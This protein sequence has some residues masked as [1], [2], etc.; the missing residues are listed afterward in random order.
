[1]YKA[2]P[3]TIPKWAVAFQKGLPERLKYSL[4]YGIWFSDIGSL[5]VIVHMW[6]YK[7]L[8]H[9]ASV[10]EA[11]VKNEIWASTVAETMN[12]LQTMDSR[13]LI[14]TVLSKLK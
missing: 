14:P 8:G 7:S 12:F 5:N 13:I 1:M 9:R 3:G 6:P 10:R 4:P 2:H 11:A